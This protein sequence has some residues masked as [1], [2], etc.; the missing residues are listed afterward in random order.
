MVGLLVIIFIAAVVGIFKPYFNG[1]KRGHFVA[2]AVVAFIGIG[3]AAPTPKPEAGSVA[4]DGNQTA[5]Q[6]S[7]EPAATATEP[8]T[9]APPASKWSYS[10]DTDEMRGTKTK[11]ASL[12]SE[13]EVD[14][15]F[16]YG[17]V[18]GQLT[19]RRRPQDGLNIMFRVAS[20]QVLCNSFSESHI[21]VKFDDKPIQRFSC[22]GTTD[23]S[24]ETAFIQG[25]AGFLR[26]LKASKKAIVE[27]EF[28]QKGR[29]QFTFETANLVW[30]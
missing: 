24:S 26:S 12:A 21:S 3:I 30:E 20:G 23:G 15:D 10:E 16:P 5:A 8:A 4:V 7:A 19:V 9:P 2:A 14:L 25:E 6:A 28:Y 17:V 1:L 18:S 22:T 13:N 11:F 27:A 29:Q